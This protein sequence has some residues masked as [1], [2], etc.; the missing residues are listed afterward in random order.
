MSCKK[1]RQV[2]ILIFLTSIVGTPHA[3]GV[4]ENETSERDKFRN[5]TAGF[6]TASVLVVKVGM[7]INSWLG[8]AGIIPGLV[9]NNQFRIWQEK[10]N[11]LSLCC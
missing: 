8:L 1:I 6:S 5:L 2:S 10:E 3:L 4:C 9:A 11:N 7:A